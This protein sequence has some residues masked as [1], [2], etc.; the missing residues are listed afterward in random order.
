ML[1]IHQARA[2]VLQSDLK[3]LQQDLATSS[4]EEQNAFETLA[5]A[6]CNRICS[7]V[8]TQLPRELRDTVYRHLGTQSDARINREYFRPT[9]DTKTRLYTYDTARW[10][11]THCPEH[12]WDLAYVGGPFFHELAQ[13]YYRTSTFIFGDENGLIERFLDTDQME[14][15]YSPR[16]LVSRVEVH[17]SAMTF[18][19]STCIG[20]MFGCA[21][22]PERLQAALKGVEGLKA[23]ASV[24]VHYTTQAKDEEQ[25]EDQVKTVCTAL[26]PS[27]KILRS[28][29]YGARLVIDEKVDVEL[30][31]G[32]SAH[33]VKVL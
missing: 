25:K 11:T 32:W 10:K 27:L 7:R 13:S 29:G 28:A 6:E 30:N 23:G 31:V 2:T 17:L 26:V 22:K 19:R 21:A 33:Q 12:F 15:G 9:M 1:R 8:M 3:A 24:C 18:D 20:Y 16:E 5:K 14:L 4:A